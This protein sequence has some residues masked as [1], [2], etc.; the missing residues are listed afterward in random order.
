VRFPVEPVV[1][2]DAKVA[3]QRRSTNLE[4]PAAGNLQ[5]NRRPESTDMIR[6]GSAGLECDEFCF[7]WVE[8]E[9]IA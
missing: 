8:A 1:D 5:V 6:V 4:S 9:A 3:D 7:I 2:E